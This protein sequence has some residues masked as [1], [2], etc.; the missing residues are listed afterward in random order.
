M[1]NTSSHA[2]VSEE[3]ERECSG[4]SIYD[5]KAYVFVASSHK[6]NAMKYCKELRLYNTIFINNDGEH[7]TLIDLLDNIRNSYLIVQSRFDFGSTNAE[8]KRV[9]ARVKRQ[10]ITVYCVTDDTNYD[11]DDS[12]DELLDSACYF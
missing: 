1:N 4:G 2:R 3:M 11:Y 8:I 6:A 9:H 7:S 12:W 5:T 10:C